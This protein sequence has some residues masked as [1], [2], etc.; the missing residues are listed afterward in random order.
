MLSLMIAMTSCVKTIENEGF[1]GVYDED[2]N[3]LIFYVDTDRIPLRVKD[4]TVCYNDPWKDNEEYCV[5]HAY[6]KDYSFEW[7]R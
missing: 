2:T 6:V 3:E 7:E 5:D 4:D 1:K